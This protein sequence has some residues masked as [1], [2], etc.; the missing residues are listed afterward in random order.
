MDGQENV[1]MQQ[2]STEPV[3]AAS[4]VVSYAPFWKRLVALFI[5]VVLLMIV[6]SVLTGGS[7][8]SNGKIDFNISSILPALISWVYSVVMVV[9]FGATLGKMAMK[10]RVQNESTGANLSWV[11]AA[12]REVVGKFLSGIAL[13]LGYFWML[14]DPKK[15]TWH[16]KIGH[17]V[18]VEAK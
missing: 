5:D 1:V 6:G 9:K 4:A 16:D 8:Y 17:S 10:I 13:S 14:W 18:V 12:L 2:Q 3:A 15:Q 7:G 11:E